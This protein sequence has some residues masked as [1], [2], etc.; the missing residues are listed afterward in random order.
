L[1]VKDYKLLLSLYIYLSL[2]IIFIKK[3]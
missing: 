3:L 2:N 1:K